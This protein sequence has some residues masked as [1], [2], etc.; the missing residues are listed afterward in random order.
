[1]QTSLLAQIL[2]WMKCQPIL[3]RNS[4]TL[5]IAQMMPGCDLPHS[6][7]NSVDN[8]SV[9][10][11]GQATDEIKLH[12]AALS[13]KSIIEFVI[14]DMIIDT[15]SYYQRVGA[16]ENAIER[17]LHSPNAESDISSLREHSKGLLAFP[18]AAN[19]LSN[20]WAQFCETH[21]SSCAVHPDL[22]P[23][24]VFWWGSNVR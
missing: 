8:F 16:V 7:D 17:L 11:L 15:D 14:R 10:I 18:D 9:W 13:L 23:G 1:M 22:W 19:Q 2:E 24:G 6:E 3:L 20:S 12:G 5:K 21:C 4:L